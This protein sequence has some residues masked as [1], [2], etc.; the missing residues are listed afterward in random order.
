MRMTYKCPHFNVDH[1]CD[2][3]YAQGLRGYTVN[4]IWESEQ[5]IR[6]LTFCP[7]KPSICY[8]IEV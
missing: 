5:D 2:L 6:T 1:G 7:M 3:G 4:M 8:K